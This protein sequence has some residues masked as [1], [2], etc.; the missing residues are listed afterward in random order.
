MFNR[1]DGETIPIV[2]VPWQRVCCSCY[3]SVPSGAYTIIHDC[4]KDDNP[5][6]LADAGIHC[7]PYW[8]HVAYMVTQQSITYNAPVK[9][10]PTSDDVTVD[11]ELTLVFSIGPGADDVKKFVYNLGVVKFNQF[12]AA[13]CEEAVRQLMRATMLEDVYEL[14][15]AGSEHVAQVL[16][17]MND[18]FN[19]FGVTFVK[20]AI[21]D[22]M[23]NSELRQI[24][25]GTTE[26]R[27]KITELDKED[28]FNMKNIGFEFTKRFAEKEREYD[29]RKQ[30]I[31]AETSVAMV[32][33]DMEAVQAESRR[34]VAVTRAEEA[35]EVGKTRADADLKVA[36]SR[37]Q[38]EN[39]DLLSKIRSQAE[40][41][42][43]HVEHDCLV[44][45]KESEGL[46][47]VEG[48]KAEATKVE[49]KGEG[50]AAK[51]LTELRKHSLRMARL[52]VVEAV[53]RRSK[54]V[55]GGDEGRV[56][57]QSVVND[58]LL[59]DFEEFDEL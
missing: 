34:E 30:D 41:D 8:K 45:V 56:I 35:A 36:K 43:I 3:F 47:A 2:A 59:G 16:R 23:L 29:R 22:V 10:C 38:R 53:A 5:D 24:L 19:P 26:F 18:K 50:E 39:A 49:A 37:A 17:I 25:Q 44:R 12:L 21:T 42:R 55:V 51:G 14:R 58:A 4:G 32:N 6:G 48:S 13:E 54:M 33:R 1:S 9:A 15:G 7:T 57:I 40:A 28:D 20:A 31:S 46:I 27:T 11:C 52:E